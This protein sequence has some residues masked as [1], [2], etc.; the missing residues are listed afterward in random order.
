MIKFFLSQEAIYNYS[1]HSILSIG[2][3]NYLKTCCLDPPTN[4]V[5]R[6]HWERLH[7]V[8]NNYMALSGYRSIWAEGA[9]IH[10][11]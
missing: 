11:R 1:L 3:S 5:S 2:M 7:F 8:Q 9:G 4:R 10:K 6:N